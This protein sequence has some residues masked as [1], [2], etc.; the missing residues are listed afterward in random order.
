M[1]SFDSSEKDQRGS[2]TKTMTKSTSD[3]EKGRRPLSIRQ[4][5]FATK[6]AVWLSGKNITPNQIS[7]TSLLFAALAALCFLLWPVFLIN[8][9]TDSIQSS[10]N[11]MVIG[12]P[13]LSALFIQLRL[14][15]N[16][17]DGL[18]AVEGA[19]STP[20]GELF[21]DIPDRISDPLI[22]VCAGYS[23][24]AVEWGWQVGWLAGLLSVMT[25]YIRNLASSIGAPVDYRGPMAKQQR[26][27]LLTIA[28]ILSAFEMLIW[29]P[30]YTLLTTLT[31]I[32]LGCIATCVR[33]SMSAYQYLEN[34]GGRACL[35]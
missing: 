7:V 17:F 21:N 10:R 19:K 15:C 20:S 8:K 1:V 5:P 33:R 22:L 6:F 23:I 31:L 27:A 13:L 18:V 26:M 2:V 30:G 16:L 12:L 11:F 9:T 29:Q 3:N 32:A 4:A 35:K 14:L 28:S 34:K 24:T 25:A